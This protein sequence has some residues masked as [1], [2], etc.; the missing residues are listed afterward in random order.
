MRSEAFRKEEEVSKDKKIPAEDSPEV[1]GHGNLP[2]NL[3]GGKGGKATE[4]AEPDVEAH[5]NLPG[6]LPGGKGN[7]PAARGNKG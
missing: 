4:D 6:N 7:I 5:G 1:E 3:P 2:G